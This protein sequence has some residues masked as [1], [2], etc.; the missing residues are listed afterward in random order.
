MFSQT[1][2]LSEGHRKLLA[3][4]IDAE[5]ALSDAN[6]HLSENEFKRRAECL[7]GANTT[8]GTPALPRR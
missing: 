5:F 6:H 3:K 7:N 2:D 1:L 4:E 8:I